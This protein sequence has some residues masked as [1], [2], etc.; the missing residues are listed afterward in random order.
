M[1][2]S[3]LALGLVFFTLIGCNNSNDSSS[4][5]SNSDSSSNNSSSI[6]EESSSTVSDV[7]VESVEIV[8]KDIVNL[9]IGQTLQLNVK[10]LPENATNKLVNYE[11]SN[12]DV[13]S[14]SFTGEVLARK[15]GNVTITVTSDDNNKTDSITLSISSASVSSFN[16]SFDESVEIV[17][18]NNT[19]YYKLDIGTDYKLN[20][21]YDSTNK[22]DEELE[23]S[24][25][26]DGYCLFDSKTNTLTPLK[27]IESLVMTLKVKG[28][29]LKQDMYLK[30][31]VA[32]K[33]DVDE[34]NAKLKASMEKENKK[35]V[36]TY[37]VNLDFDTVS[38]YTGDKTHAIQKTT[39]NVYK[40]SMNRY[41]IGNTT[42][43]NTF[44]EYGATEAV[45]ENFKSNIFKGMSDDGNYYAFQVYEDG[46][47][48]VT[49]IKKTIVDEVSSSSNQIT[50]ADAITNSTK[51]I[52]NSHVGLSDIATLHFAGLYE[53]SIGFGSIPM[54]F[55]G[56]AAGVN[57][58]IVEANNVITATTFVIE[59]LP[60]Q[61]SNGK[62]F[63]NKGVYTFND[64]GILVNINVKSLVYDKTSFDFNKLELKENAKYYEMYN[65]ELSQ[66]FGNLL[67][68]ETN[69]LD[70]SKLY[71]TDFTPV[72]AN[73]KGEKTTKFE[74]GQKY[75]ISYLN[76]APKYADSRID[77]IIIDESS[78]LDVATIINEG[79]S[80]QI[81]SAGTTTLT[82]YST[83]NKVKKEVVIN[84]GETLPTSMEV[85]VNGKKMATV[86][87]FVNESVD[88]ISFNV[89]PEVAS[90]DIDVTVNGKGTITK[91]ANGT[92][93][94]TSD[95]EGTS[96]IVA[97]SKLDGTVK[98]S[99]TINVTKKEEVN[100]IL[101]VLLKNT[102]VCHDESVE[103]G[104][105]V[106]SNSLKFTSKTTAVLTIIDGRETE[107]T[108]NLNVVIDDANNT[109][110]FTSFTAIDDYYDDSMYILPLIKLNKAYKVAN[111]GSSFEV[112]LY[113]VE[114]NTEYDY[115]EASTVLV[116]YTFEISK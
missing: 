104:Y 61:A 21:T 47:H 62:A 51:I 81:E 98:A 60:S 52:M 35:T 111:D 88:N 45:E 54:Y 5:D 50:R 15:A 30:I 2:K 37:Q 113:F 99:L 43:H 109:I 22:D 70:P 85:L 65:I 57:L 108:I 6:V 29:N 33:K 75:H 18:S 12:E 72:F 112:N 82:I 92:Y 3:F 100:S 114:D 16:A 56:T 91:N 110:T 78:N 28:T 38:K 1:K 90:Q 9:K 10:V 25:D 11:S 68:Q 53:N 4:F 32:G 13:A 31:N 48:A 63:F 55:G 40:D 116:P 84:V 42:T 77:S 106:I 101:D 36:Q 87:T 34:M 89:L 103:E 95:A 20:V 93:S 46:Y 96:T 69:E 64:E 102:Y 23:A 97:T 115:G 44:L 73:S 105:D 83:K 26:V 41:M 79:R 7:K 71:F 14:V 59:E 39:Y 67:T 80:I 76:P 94:F 17:K 8:N 66:T 19:T 24:F 86:D 58:N 27:T 107:Y 74:V 49:P